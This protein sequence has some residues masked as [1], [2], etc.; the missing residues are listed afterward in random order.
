MNGLNVS[1]PPFSMKIIT[2]SFADSEKVYNYLL[3]SSIHDDFYLDN[4]I[5]AIGKPNRAVEIRG[6]NEKFENLYLKEL[7]K[8]E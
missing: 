8:G 2:Q 3:G 6:W 1:T 4:L 5:L 7:P